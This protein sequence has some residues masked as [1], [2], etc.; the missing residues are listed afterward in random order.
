MRSLAV[1]LLFAAT[2]PAAD[3]LTRI[4]AGYTL[5][6]VMPKPRVAVE[7]VRTL[8]ILADLARLAEFQ[9]SVAEPSRRFY[10][11]VALYERELHADWPTILD[12]VF[13]H[14]VALGAMFGVDNGPA[15]IVAEG[16]D[17]ERVGEFF[18]LVVRLIE[19]EAGTSLAKRTDDGADIITDGKELHAARRGAT[20]YFSNKASH[21]KK[22]LDL[23]GPSLANSA[24]AA[25][26]LVGGDPLLW[27]W[28]DLK[29]LK[30]NKASEDFFAA[31]RKDF[32]QTVV[33][34]ASIDAVRRADLV[35]VGLHRTKTGA[36]LEFK[37]PAKRADLPPEFTL[38][39]PAS[40]PGSLPLLRPPGT[41]YSQ[42]F[43]LDLAT[44]WRERAKLINGQQL[45]DVEKAEKD[46]STLLPNI[47]LGKLLEM[48]GAYH[49]VVVADVPGDAYKT[50]PV[51]SLPAAALVVSMRDE[52]FGKTMSAALRAGAFA[53]TL[54]Y[55]LKMSTQDIDGVKV[56]CYRFPEEVPFPNDADP[57]RLRFN[58][59]PCFAVVG[60]QLVVATRPE[61][62]KALLP[63]LR[64][65]GGGA[66]PVWRGRAELGGLA[67]FLEQHPEPIIARGLLD[68][69][70]SLAA[71]KK[72]A[73]ETL[74]W[75]AT[76][77]GVEL[78]LDHQTDAY[79]I[80][81]N[82]E[83]K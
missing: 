48:S 69:G 17:T 39:V 57:D 50:K 70:L 5:A 77:G 78:N 1:L 75:L 9:E 45:K 67:A 44:L 19:D 23:K 29:S 53:A 13:G 37:L 42:S 61:L 76:L 18:K 7:A 65:T 16:T 51:T 56:V 58:V 74:R 14:G 72:R 27:A 20:L 2:A 63:E 31:T 25:R 8:P 66:V 81:F 26:P 43:Y 35:A 30:A 41:L 10:E 62:V 52:Q 64:R 73:T 59:V 36:R 79:V 40:G 68:Q 4:P 47:T 15:L 82:W 12:K 46:L 60:D 3:P 55:K 21:L 34:G 33:V 54:Q 83:A 11:L 28:L 22:A 6:V 49:R 80:S 38:H 24:S 71:A 32:L